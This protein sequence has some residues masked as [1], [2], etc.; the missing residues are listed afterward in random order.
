M[1]DDTHIS[2]PFGSDFPATEVVEE[3]TDSLDLGVARLDL[4]DQ[5]SVADFVA[6]WL[7]PLHVLVRGAGRRPG[8]R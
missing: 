2:T 6:G 3:W 7:G 1:P 4:A 8:R 5:S